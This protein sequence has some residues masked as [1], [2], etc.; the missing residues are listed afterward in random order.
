VYILALTSK[1]ITYFVIFLYLL[2]IWL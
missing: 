1:W 2:F